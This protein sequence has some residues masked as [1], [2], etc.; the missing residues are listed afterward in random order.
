MKVD[1]VDEDEDEQA[2]T[3]D[4]ESILQDILY[5]TLNHLNQHEVQ[6]QHDRYLLRLLMDT[7]G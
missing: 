4:T 1:E 7:D 3:H 2:I 5:L 6:V